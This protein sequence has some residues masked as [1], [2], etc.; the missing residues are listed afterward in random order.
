[1]RVVR[2]LR[3]VWI[4]LVVLMVIACGGFTVSRVHGIFGSEKRPLYADGQVQD[5]KPFNPKQVIY[6]VFGSAGAVAAISYFDVNSEPDQVDGACLPWSLK[7]TTTSPAVVGNIVAQGDS[8]S[9]GCRIMVDGQV[10][11]ER[12][13]N[14]VNAYTHC[15]VKGA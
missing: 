14:E 9:I 10:K 3:R 7:I 1:M 6:E 8:D 13:S 12:I 15:P 5:T 11:A 2:V 4:P